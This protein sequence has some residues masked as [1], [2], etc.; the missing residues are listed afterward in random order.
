MRE[1]LLALRENPYDAQKAYVAAHGYYGLRLFVKSMAVTN[2]IRL[3]VLPTWKTETDKWRTLAGM[4]LIEMAPECDHDHPYDP[5]EPKGKFEMPFGFRSA[6]VCVRSGTRYVRGGCLVRSDKA[7]RKETYAWRN[8]I[9]AYNKEIKKE[10]VS[11][12]LEFRSISRWLE[13]H[14]EALAMWRKEL[15]KRR[16]VVV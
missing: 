16:E 4:L 13:E 15:A 10:G 5:Q 11:A 7:D 1:L 12:G 2:K 3:M 9:K 6:S 14:P 8:L